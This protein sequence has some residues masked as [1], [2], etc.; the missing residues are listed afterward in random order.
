[1]TWL[2]K[3]IFNFFL[4]ALLV[5]NDIFEPIVFE[6]VNDNLIDGTITRNNIHFHNH[7]NHVPIHFN[8]VL[9]CNYQNDVLVIQPIDVYSLKVVSHGL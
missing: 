4:E 1:M 8:N 6:L 7:H 9:I 2:L 3:N 5:K